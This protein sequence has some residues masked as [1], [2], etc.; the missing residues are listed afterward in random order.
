LRWSV[1]CGGRAWT[2]THERWLRTHHFE[3]PGLQLAY[4]TARDTM[5][6]T[7][8]RRARLD[9]AITARA[10][11]SAYTPVVTRLGC[12]RG[13]STLTGFGLAVEIGDWQRLTGHSIGRLPGPGAHRV[14]L[15]RYTLAGRDHQDRQRP[16]PAG[17]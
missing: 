9:E 2:R 12:L 7:L 8:A 5:L 14:L 13:I 1:Y 6:A 11:D 3:L 17:C 16:T 15:R 10:A 4:D